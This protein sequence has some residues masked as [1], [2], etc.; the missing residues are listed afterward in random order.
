MRTH[1]TL[2]LTL[3]LLL[4]AGGGAIAATA[5]S[6]PTIAATTATVADTA[7]TVAETAIA[8]TT[9]AGA[10]TAT[11]EVHGPIVLVAGTA[12][13]TVDKVW[14]RPS[15]GA[16]NSSAAYFTVTDAGSP[17]RLV[18]VSTPAAALAELHES[19]DDHGVMKMRGIAG[20]AL[21]PGKP[22]NFAP[23][24]YHVMLMGLTKPLKAGDSFPLTLRFEHAAPITVAVT[25]QTGPA[26]AAVP[27]HTMPAGHDMPMGSMPMNHSGMPPAT[28]PG[29]STAG[30]GQSTGSGQN[31]GSGKT[32]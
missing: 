4:T 25:V 28:T 21:E 3:P 15:I 12:G 13:I 8:A 1:V 18:G 31:T 7:A 17:D 2:L 26:G 23:G 10:E 5:I 9:G 20:V 32:N 22:V 27:G 14:A 24:G 30:A 6:T 19:I 11:T 16:A 29:Q